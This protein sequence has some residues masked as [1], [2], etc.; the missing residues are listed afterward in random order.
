M[1]T[2][3]FLLVMTSARAFSA[4]DLNHTAWRWEAPFEVVQPG[5]VR[6]E[7]TPPLLDVARTDL[8]DLRVL[9]PQGAE[10][11]YLFGQVLAHAGVVREAVD[12]KTHLSGTTTVIEVSAGTTSRIEAVVLVSPAAEFLKS[13]GIEGRKDGG[14]WESIAPNE[15]IF[16]QTGGAERMR[17]PLAAGVWQELRFT[18][19]DGRSQPVPFTGVRVI[20]AAQK[21]ETTELP[22]TLGSRTDSAA[23]SRLTLDLGGSNL[24]IAELL[25]DIP[26]AVFSRSCCVA[27]TTTTQDAGTHTEIIASGNIYRV[28]G[29]HGVAVE[30]LAIPIHRRIPQRVVHLTLRNGDSPPLTI[31][32]AKVRHHPTVIE[33]HADLTG[34]WEVLAGNREARTTQY[35]L[36]PLRAAIAGV[37]GQRISPGT[38]RAN[39]D[40]ARPEAL[41]GVE[42][43]GAGID[44]TEWTRRRAVT[45]A[46]GVIRI[47]LDA[48]TLAATRTD[49]GDIRLIQNGVQIPYLKRPGTVTRE[50]KPASVIAVN[51]PKRPTVSRWEVTLP[52]EG[53][54]AADLTAIST[55]AL[56]TRTFV[57][58]AE[59]KDHLG[60]AWSEALGSADWTKSVSADVPLVMN[61]GG[62]RLPEKFVLET[63]HGDN[64]P[65]PVDGVIVRYAAPSI[66]TKLT[67]NAPVFIYY[68]NPHAPQPQYDLRLVR[69]ELLASEPHGTTLGDEEMLKP[70]TREKRRVDAGS[71][72]L[73]LALGAVVIVLLVIVARLLPRPDGR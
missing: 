33:F 71:P 69:D 18:V 55:A 41:P 23:E 21:P 44:L 58:I 47:E 7:V 32:G 30:G 2:A 63:D 43:T 1:K 66:T 56:F 12:F 59:R 20:T 40:F 51:D 5:M 53:L 57:A 54:P 65:V 24:D 35:D 37:S 28:V 50:L 11:P 68:G 27:I 29:D 42:T 70:D 14:A 48:Q 19:D 13:V 15:V 36:G 49:L 6:L 10:T 4:T 60:N 73:W 31:Q 52:M 9:A 8:G 17:M 67:D 61:L 26:D 38:L 34:A 3:I 46:A 22:V 64:P 16:R 25:L 72:W 39:P 45:A 62:R